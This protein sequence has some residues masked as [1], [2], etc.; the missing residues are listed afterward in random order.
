M[1]NTNMTLDDI[2]SGNFKSDFKD[3]QANIDEV[4]RL[5]NEQ[6]IFGK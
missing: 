4:A 5:A 6:A 3:V 2:L 1:T